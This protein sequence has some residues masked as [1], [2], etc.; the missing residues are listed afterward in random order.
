MANLYVTINSTSRDVLQDGTTITLEQ[1][2]GSARLVINDLSANIAISV[3]D[4]VVVDDGSS[5]I[6]A[7]YVLR[8][9]KSQGKLKPGQRKLT[10]D[11]VSSS[12]RMAHPRALISRA[13]EN[14]TDQNIV[15]SLLEAAKL[16][17][18]VDANAPFWAVTGNI[19]QTKT[20]ITTAFGPRATA[21]DAMNQLADMTGA[22]WFIDAANVFHWN[23]DGSADTAPWNVDTDSPNN[24][25]TFDVLDLQ[26]T[27]SA[28]AIANE[29]EVIG[30]NNGQSIKA[31]DSDATSISSYGIFA[32][33]IEDS[34]WVNQSTVDEI[35]A[36][37]VAGYKDPGFEFSFA[38]R[39]DGLRPN[40][41][42]TLTCAD[43]G[44]SARAG[45]IR[46]VEMQQQASGLT[47]Y[48]V[49]GGDR[50]RVIETLLRRLKGKGS[51]AGLGPQIVR[52]LNFARASSEK[53]DSGGSVANLD[54]MAALSLRITFSLASLPNASLGLVSKYD[55]AANTGWYLELNP[56]FGTF[57]FWRTYSIT[58]YQRSV[59][60]PTL[61]A[62]EPHVLVVVASP[63]TQPK[64]WLDGVRLTA[65]S[66]NLGS[67]TVDSDAGDALEVATYDGGNYF[68]GLLADLVIW[69]MA[70]PDTTAA[71][72]HSAPI[73][74]LPFLSDIQL[75]WKMDEF[76]DGDPAT[77]A[78][79]ILDRG[80][81]GYDGTPTNTPTGKSVTLL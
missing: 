7:G 17:S 19:D 2:R 57:S 1:P 78:G 66:G 67:G 14:E 4:E 51:K 45:V 40:Q 8:V 37:A 43:F 63:T 55:A 31:T 73:D 64:F 54:D 75:I 80:P 34:G 76:D 21:E 22:H 77:A 72:A 79:S 42:I 15:I 3:L 81:N 52:G 69:D 10:L 6:F 5:N 24:S 38:T 39:Q 46:R 32:L 48:R 41:A 70:L 56:S 9:T 12:W 53:V 35:A 49:T 25:T 65:G 61:A 36:A 18:N 68:D 33:S 16:R 11:C 47:Y 29:V 20:G 44:L 13:Y 59:S 58:V 30:G 23:A 27:D 28:D 50:P 26:V 62:N 74:G 71:T 60:G